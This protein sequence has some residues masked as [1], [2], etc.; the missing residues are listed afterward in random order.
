ME[1][2]RA[3]ASEGLMLR[4]KSSIKVRQPLASLSI[5]DEVA[6]E[7][8]SI[9]AEELNVKEIIMH[10]TEEEM[11]LDT[12][13]TPEL[14][15]EGDVRE[16]MR[17]LADARKEQGLAPKDKVL[18]QINEDA[19]GTLEGVT[20]PGVHAVTFASEEEANSF[21]YSIQLSEGKAHFAITLS[22]NPVSNAA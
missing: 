20:L 8:A 12:R 10:S 21:A 9:I 6:P 15:R 19:R 16:F 4:Q 3:I 1:R 11:K 2:V 5:P 13:I 18:V 17:A 22:G 7:L 14:M